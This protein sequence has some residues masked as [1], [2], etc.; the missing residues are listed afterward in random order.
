MQRKRRLADGD[1]GGVRC[2]TCLERAHVLDIRVYKR[3]TIYRTRRCVCGH[4]GVWKE[5]YVGT[6]RRRAPHSAAPERGK[7]RA[8]ERDELNVACERE[9]ALTLKK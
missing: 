5:V 2:P 8:K 1:A 7:R 9:E 3:S 6:A 4:M